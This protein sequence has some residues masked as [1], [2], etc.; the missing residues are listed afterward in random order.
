MLGLEGRGD[1][2]LMCERDAEE[3][4]R[5]LV[6]LL[7][8]GGFSQLPNQQLLGFPLLS[9]YALHSMKEDIFLSA[10]YIDNFLLIYLYQNFHVVILIVDQSVEPLRNRIRQLHLLRNHIRRLN[11]T[12]ALS[13]R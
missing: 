10:L 6:S 1:F 4:G 12:Y 3:P 13:V 8:R 2:A 11:G 7:K 5:R 9:R